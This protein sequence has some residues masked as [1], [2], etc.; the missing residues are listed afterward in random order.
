MIQDLRDPELIVGNPN[1]PERSSLLNRLQLP[2]RLSKCDLWL[3]ILPF[4]LW[5][6]L[7]QVRPWILHTHC[8]PDLSGCPKEQVL[9]MDRPGLGIENSPA[10][11]YSFF[12]QNLS[13]VLAA[14]GPIAYQTTRVALG[15]A[16]PASAMALAGTDLVLFLESW[17][18]N[19]ALTEGIR[20]VAQRPRPYVYS[21]PQQGLDPQNYVSFYSGHT[22]FAATACICLLLILIGRGAPTSVLL[23][24]AALSQCLIISTAAYR[25]LSGR[26]FLSDV[27]AGAVMG[28]AVAILIAILHRPKLRQVPQ[29]TR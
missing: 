15:I 17:G 8:G 23:F 18:I 19:G 22:S 5:T 21:N 20:L 14:S 6:A 24:T 25:I 28:G 16:S 13:G 2:P 11:G 4:L 7:V 27:L 1:T 9:P 26:H 12:T 3:T 10:D 29:M